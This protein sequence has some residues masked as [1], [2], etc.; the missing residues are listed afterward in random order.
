MEDPI[1]FFNRKAIEDE[2]KWK[3]KQIINGLREERK[4]VNKKLHEELTVAISEREE[5]LE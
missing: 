3:Q 1:W 4:K 2:K 5:R